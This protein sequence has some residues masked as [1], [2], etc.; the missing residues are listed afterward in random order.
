MTQPSLPNLPRAFLERLEQIVPS[1]KLPGVLGS[2]GLPKPVA[3]RVN[4]LR[5]GVPAVTRELADL[6]FSAR[7]LTWCR[8]AYTVETSDRRRLTGS[9]AFNEGRIYVQNPSSMLVPL[10]LDPQPG[11]TVL[12]L[13][14]APG[15]KT[16]HVAALMNDRGRLSAVEPVRGRYYKLVANLRRYGATMVTCYRHDGRSVGTKCP[17]MFDRVLLDAPCSSEARF[18]RL[19]PGSWEHWNLRKIRETSRKQKGL[20]RSA[21]RCLKPGGVLVYCT[22]SFAPEENEM[23]VHSLLRRFGDAVEILPVPLPYG[24]AQPGL[25]GWKGREFHSDLAKSVRILPDDLMDALYICRLRK[26]GPT[27]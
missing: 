9:A 3:F 13:A 21:I 19:D 4:T 1:D 7:P 6:G 20:L 15:G 22:C 23:V 2:L 8:G 27:P 5:A 25:T 11:E 18:T 24:D 17:G 12:D 10:A 26:T 16:L 14:A